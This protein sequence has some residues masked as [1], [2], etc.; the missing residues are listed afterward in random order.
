MPT[1]YADDTETE[2]SAS[3]AKPQKVK[4]CIAFLKR[5]SAAYRDQRQ[6]EK[7]DLEFQV[8]ENAW[9]DGVKAMMKGSTVNNVPLPDRPM[10]SIDT[11]S[12]PIQLVEN[13]YRAAHL[14]I[15]IHPITPDAT[16]YSAQVLQGI[17]R[18]I[19]V[20]SRASAI[21]R[22]WSFSR[23]T[24]CGTGGYEVASEYDPDTG[25]PGDQRIVLK[26]V[27]YQ[28]GI[29]LDPFGQQPDWSD[30]EE[31]AIVVDLPWTVYK[32]KYKKTKLAAY[33]DASLTG[34]GEDVPDWVTGDGDER[35]IRIARYFYVEHDEQDIVLK[36]AGADGKDI[37][38]QQDTRSV[39]WCIVNA[40]EELQSGEW[41]GPYIPIIPT[42]GK[43]LIPY[44]GKRR[45]IG[46]ISNAKDGV[47][48][49]NYAASG[50][51]RMA[52]LEP[53]APWMM[54]EGQDEGHELEFL[55]SN[56][57]GIPIHY[58]MKNT[59]GGQAREKPSRV[60]V[61][62]SRLGP[63]M[64]LLSMGKDFVQRATAMFPPS[65]GENT[66][67]HRSGKAIEALQGQGLEG[68]S[69]YTANLADIS[70]TY[71]AMVVLAAIPYFYDRPGRI[72]TILDGEDQPSQVILNH[73]FV[74]DPQ[75]KKPVAIPN[76]QKGQPVPPNAKYVNL[77]EGRYGVTVTVGKSYKSLMEQGS[78]EIGDIMQA[79]PALVPLIGP[80]YFRYR[81]FPGSRQ[82]AETL[83][84]QRDHAMPWLADN[85][86]NAQMDPQRLAAEN[87]QLKQHLQE[88]GQMIQTK[89]IEQQGK[90]EIVKIQESAESQRSHETN[91]TKMAVAELSGKFQTLADSMKLF[92]EESR[93]IGA[94]IHESRMAAEDRAHGV[95]TAALDHAHT[96]SEAQHAHRQE[97]AQ[98]QQEHQQ[99]LEQAAQAADLAPKPAAPAEQP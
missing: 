68:S 31:G 73:P 54:E 50:A 39:K 52:A 26:R 14:G 17:Y 19:E 34:L 29:H 23:S 44:D 63:N 57:R 93:L 47:R 33:N 86:Q 22:G 83:K 24:K 97:L 37:T 8:P 43:E 16:D 4:D 59:E 20:Q 79:D 25:V 75:T 36:G 6:R 3:P 61:D 18:S 5:S 88:A 94:R 7:D 45:W 38:F 72:V 42:I 60:Q 81:D 80:T 62:V 48:L 90:V 96:I 30:G 71:E 95:A 27:L 13:Q 82:I 49:T 92:I 91:E 21:P 74:I 67:A 84:K 10:L 70:M 1:D 85:P 2:E 40:I 78:S 98:G 46:M 28:E 66:P 77:N 55:Q 99:A 35:T 65:L 41:P 56:T 12:E 51:V 53:E 9:P 89:T 87:A 11:L 64:Q 15:N 69:N 76:W 32:R 58:R